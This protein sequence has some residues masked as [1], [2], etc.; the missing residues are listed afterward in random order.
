[1]IFIAK[2]FAKVRITD[3]LSLHIGADM[4]GLYL[5]KVYL[6]SAS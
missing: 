5:S 1:M 3:T 2:D 4:D 6:H